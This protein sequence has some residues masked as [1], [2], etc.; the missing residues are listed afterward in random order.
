MGFSR[1]TSAIFAL[2]MSAFS[3]SLISGS[4]FTT[5]ATCVSEYSAERDQSICTIALRILMPRKYRGLRAIESFALKV[6]CPRRLDIVALRVKV[7]PLQEPAPC[8]TSPKASCSSAMI[9]GM[10]W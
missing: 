9:A 3:E 10:R 8:Q 2:T 6:T 7:Y 5:A 4:S 1:A